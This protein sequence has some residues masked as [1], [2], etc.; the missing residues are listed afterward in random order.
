MASGIVRVS[1]W[2]APVS[3]M[4]ERGAR[5]KMSYDWLETV[6]RETNIKVGFVVFMAV[7]GKYCPG[8]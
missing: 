8:M 4:R 7:I 5:G 2:E 1:A 6:T 3:V